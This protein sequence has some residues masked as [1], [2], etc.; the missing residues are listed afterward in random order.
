MPTT[1]LSDCMPVPDFAT[2]NELPKDFCLSCV[3]AVSAI[4]C[5]ECFSFNKSDPTCGDPFNPAYG[6]YEKDC[7]QGKDGRV[8]GFPAKYCIKIIG[9][10]GT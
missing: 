6:Q 1:I 2:Q 3:I 7:S 9:T 4:D 10:T 8:G 5:Y